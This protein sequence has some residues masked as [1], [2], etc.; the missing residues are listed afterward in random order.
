MWLPACR[1]Y[2]PLSLRSQADPLGHGRSRWP[3]DPGDEDSTSRPG[4]FQDPSC[5]SAPD[6]Q[7]DGQPAAIGRQASRTTRPAWATVTPE[8]QRA[9]L[10][11]AQSRQRFQPSRPRVTLPPGARRDLIPLGREL[12]GRQ[13]VQQVRRIPPAV[14]GRRG[15]GYR[16]HLQQN[17]QSRGGSLPH[18]QGAP[19]TP[20]TESR[21]RPLFLRFRRQLS[22]L[23]SGQIRTLSITCSRTPGPARSEARRRAWRAQRL[24][25]VGT[26][27]CSADTPPNDDL[28]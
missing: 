13:T 9:C 8:L 5:G 4:E 19:G 17:P 1:G 16:Q 26:A 15:P 24:S 2:L 12:L 14:G 21:R 25:E 7:H 27:A 28:S 20:Q 23:D 18:L 11:P 3:R 22:V 10:E 6:P